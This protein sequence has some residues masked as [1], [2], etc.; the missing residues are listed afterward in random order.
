MATAT[1]STT[2]ALYN[3]INENEERFVLSRRRAAVF[4]FFVGVVVLSLIFLIRMDIDLNHNNLGERAS[5]INKVTPI[6]P[7]PVITAV[8]GITAASSNGSEAARNIIQ[9]NQR[10]PRLLLSALFG[11]LYNRTDFLP[12]KHNYSLL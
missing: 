9:N 8:D 1:A 7:G 3:S 2:A 12:V 11:S 6:L 5:I 10:D 4:I